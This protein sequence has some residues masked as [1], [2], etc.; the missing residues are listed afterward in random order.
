MREK[1]A[2]RLGGSD[3]V[4]EFDVVG[5]YDLKAFHAVCRLEVRPEESL[6]LS[7]AVVGGKKTRDI[8]SAWVN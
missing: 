2:R 3:Q 8:T 7:L 6:G 1:P 4:S 5:L